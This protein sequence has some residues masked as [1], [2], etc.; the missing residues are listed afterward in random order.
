MRWIFLALL[1]SLCGGLA[2]GQEV[3]DPESKRGSEILQ[4]LSASQQ[5]ASDS[6]L[7]EAWIAALRKEF[8]QEHV[9]VVKALFFSGKTLFERGHYSA[10]FRCFEQLVD[11]STQLKG[12]EHSKEACTL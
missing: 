2:L 4:E 12:R 1:L 8:G 11:V 6:D 3:E 5:F 7:L 10:A 9:L